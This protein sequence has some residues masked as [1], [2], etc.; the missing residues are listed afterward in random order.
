MSLFR[1]PLRLVLCG[2]IPQAAD[3]QHY[4]PLSHGKI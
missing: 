4:D 1:S 3:R 2:P